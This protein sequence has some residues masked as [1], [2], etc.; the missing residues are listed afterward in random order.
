MQ[1]FK[2]ILLVRSSLAG[3]RSALRRAVSLARS[4]RARL[5]AV[6]VVPD[7]PSEVLEYSA[8][9]PRTDVRKIV[10]EQRREFLKE[11]IEPARAEHIRCS[12][13]VLTGPPFLEIIRQVLRKDH[14]LVIVLLTNHLPQIVQSMAGRL[15]FV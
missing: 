9:L 5:T 14:D 7:F 10:L 3:S 15:G 2:N 11:F 13:Q 12:V 8:L 4:N 1:R 6:E